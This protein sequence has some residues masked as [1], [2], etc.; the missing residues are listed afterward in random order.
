MFQL[1][2]TNLS[3]LASVAVALGICFNPSI[4][5]AFSLTFNPPTGSS[6]TINDRAGRGGDTNDASINKNQIIFDQ[7]FVTS[8]G[9]IQVSGNLFGEYITY[10][11]TEDDTNV[12]LSANGSNGIILTLTDFQLTNN[13]QSSINLYE[14]LN[15]SVSMADFGF[16]VLSGSQIDFYLNYTGYYQQSVGSSL[17]TANYD[18]YSGSENTITLQ[19][20]PEAG[21]SFSPFSSTRLRIIDQPA[22]EISNISMDILNISLAS[23]ASLI[24]PDSLITMQ[25]PNDS[26]SPLTQE[27]IEHLSNLVGQKFASQSIPE[28]SSL[29]GLIALAG[30]FTFTSQRINKQKHQ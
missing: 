20:T 8:N 14:F 2:N 29:L 19:G 5:S 12:A 10:T 17:V 25:S 15:I 3:K 9:N 28:P 13:T 30:L 27:N 7:T 24:L 21:N 1:T 16:D 26:G 11:R 4:A 22:V 18:G 23:G 6:L